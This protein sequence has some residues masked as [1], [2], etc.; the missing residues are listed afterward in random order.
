MRTDIG[1]G[2]LCVRE[3]LKC[4]TSTLCA[5]T[6][7]LTGD[8]FDN[9]KR[10]ARFYAQESK[11]R[12]VEDGAEPTIAGSAGTLELTQVWPDLTAMLVL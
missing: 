3:P 10:A 1:S 6:Q 7:L 8:D 2:M 12:I 4:L 11:A 9:A 5:C